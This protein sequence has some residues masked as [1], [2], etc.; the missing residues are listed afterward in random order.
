MHKMVLA[1]QIDLVIEFGY[2]CLFILGYTK[3]TH[4]SE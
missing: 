4:K 2:L 3:K 1:L